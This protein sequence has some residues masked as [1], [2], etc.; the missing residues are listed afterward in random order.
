[1]HKLNNQSGHIAVTS[2][3]IIALLL[4]S[5]LVSV[6]FLN[7]FNSQNVLATYLKTQSS[8]AAKACLSIAR[9]GVLSN[10]NYAA[11][12]LSLY[13]NKIGQCSIKSVLPTS[14]FPKTIIVEGR[15]PPNSTRYAVT[16]LNV[17]IDSA[18][19]V[20]LWSEN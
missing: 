13:L 12:S 11:D 15:Y 20:L 17:V 1:M 14:G 6:S 8:N 18:N 9:V 10:L 3:L 5:T 2:I 7:Y 4:I 16:N 19:K